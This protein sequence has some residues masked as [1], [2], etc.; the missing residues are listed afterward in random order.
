MLLLD[1]CLEPAVTA[2]LRTLGLDVTDTRLLGVPRAT[3]EDLVSIARD[4][5]AVFVT[6]DSDFTTTALLA[7]MAAAGVCVVRIRRPSGAPVFETAAIILRHHRDW[8]ASMGEP[9][10]ISCTF[11]GGCRIRLIADLPFVV[12]PPA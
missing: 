2:A 10:I 11:K 8:L 6:Y 5:S 3:D 7:A 9:A 12:D 4:L 1:Q